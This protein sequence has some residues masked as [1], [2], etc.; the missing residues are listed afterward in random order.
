MAKLAKAIQ[1]TAPEYIKS[2]DF[3]LSPWRES[4]SPFSTATGISFS[5]RR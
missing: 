4:S 5:A 2:G 3:A 1:Q